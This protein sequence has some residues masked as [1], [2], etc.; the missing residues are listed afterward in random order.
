LQV[1]EKLFQ[2]SDIFS[3]GDTDPSPRVTQE[4]VV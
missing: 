2:D 4:P 3:S 1:S